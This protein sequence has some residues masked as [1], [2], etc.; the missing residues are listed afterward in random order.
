MIASIAAEVAKLR[1]VLTPW[2][3][4][5]GALAF[6]ALAVGGTIAAAADL[7]VDLESQEGMRSLLGGGA[8]GGGAL[9]MIV[10]ILMVA[11]EFRHGTITATLLGEPRRPRVVLAKLVAAA[12]AGVVIGVATVVLTLAIALPWLA[13]EGVEVALSDRAVW[14]PLLG[15]MATTVL[16]AVLGAGIGALVPNQVAAVS[17]AVLLVFVVEPLIV[18]FLPRVGR[19]LPGGAASALSDAA[20]PGLLPMWGGALV[21]TAYAVAAAVAGARLLTGRDIA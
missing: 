14:L 2:L 1:T 5:A 10:G 11:S 18:T 17:V 6:T 8:S 7:G 20:L 12:L 19:W 4:L 13:A 9:A 15:G 21:L 3:L 16:Y